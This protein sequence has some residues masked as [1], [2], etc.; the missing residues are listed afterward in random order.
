MTF[1]ADLLRG[2]PVGVWTVEP[3]TT[4][5][6]ALEIMAEKNV[7]ALPVVD[8]G[9]VVGMFSERDYARKV[10]LS[11]KSSRAIAVK[12]VMSRPVFCVGPEDTLET[13]IALMTD[14]HVR[15]LPVLD[16]G[17]L[18]GLVSIGDALKATIAGQEKL[19][20]ELRDYITGA[21]S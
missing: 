3:R 17:Q 5:Y 14:R 7:G 9:D 19:I 10:E 11:S 20:N 15:H 13:C 16:G 2:K 12:E 21:H 6:R 1:V 18:I 8:G 4:V